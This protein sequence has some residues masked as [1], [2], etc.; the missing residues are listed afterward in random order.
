[1][2]EALDPAKLYKKPLAL[3]HAERRQIDQEVPKKMSRAEAKD[4]KE[5]EEARK[6]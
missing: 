5:L 3:S 6:V 2:P 4:K 1:M